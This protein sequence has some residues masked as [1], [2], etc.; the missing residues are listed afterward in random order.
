VTDYLVDTSGS[1]SHVV[2]E[3]D[4]TA[5]TPT[6]KALY[7]R[8]D[9]LL[10]VMRPLVSAP[11]SAADW[12]T[13]YYHADGLGSIR[14]LTDEAAN[15]TDG[16]TYTAFGE[17]LAHTGSDLQPYAFTGEPLDPNSGFQYHRARWME[18]STG[19]FTG[20]D[21]W[22]GSPFE[23]LTLHRYLYANLDPVNL[24]DPSGYEGLGT[25]LSALSGAV[26]VFLSNFGATLTNAFRQGGPVLGEFFQNLGRFAQGTGMEV[27]YAYQRFRP[28]LQVLPQ[29]LAGSGTRVIDVFLRLGDRAAWIEMKFGLPWKGGETLTRLVDQVRQALATG[30]GEVVLWSLKEPVTRQLSLLR[31]ALGNDYARVRLVYGVQGLGQWLSE[32]FGPV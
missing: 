32:F 23:P 28:A 5:A 11:A 22:G 21:P 30:E 20:M 3:T 7:I 18:P 12:Q 9:D 14:R 2:A 6:L 24:I 13:R 16:Y 25:Q 26:T 19:R 17:L 10:A 4:P 1:L 31:G 29:R 27:I 8:G 15:V